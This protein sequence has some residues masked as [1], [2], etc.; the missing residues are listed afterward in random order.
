MF[1]TDDNGNI[2]NI[3]TELTDAFDKLYD[4]LDKMTLE[5]RIAWYAK[6]MYI[7]P[8]KYTQ[9]IDNTIY[10][11]RTHFDQNADKTILHRFENIVEKE[12]I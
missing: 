5:E 8:L 10:V 12:S 9:E 6:G 1:Y 11:V 2:L 7:K 3:R 4:K